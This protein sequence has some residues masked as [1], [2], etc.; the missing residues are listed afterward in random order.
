MHYFENMLLAVPKHTVPRTDPH[1]S[2][3]SSQVFGTGSIGAAISWPSPSSL[4]YQRAGRGSCG[5]L[6]WA[7]IQQMWETNLDHVLARVSWKSVCSENVLIQNLLF[8]GQEGGRLV[9][10]AAIYM[11]HLQFD[12]SKFSINCRDHYFC[13]QSHNFL[14]ILQELLRILLK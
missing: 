14:A 13:F 5:A 4:A 10:A 9:C 2:F 3:D 6:H 1:S 8:R 11:C 7:K 12:N